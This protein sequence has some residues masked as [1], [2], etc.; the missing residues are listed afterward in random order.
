MC[1][2]GS[3][4]QSNQGAGQ[5]VGSLIVAGSG[6]YWQYWRQSGRGTGSRQ[7][8]RGGNR[9]GAAAALNR[10]GARWRQVRAT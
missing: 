9:A 3:S 6:Q 10:G 2:A 5:A 1:A 8:N 7:S 4:G